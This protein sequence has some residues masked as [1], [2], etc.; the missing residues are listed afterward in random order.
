MPPLSPGNT[1]QTHKNTHQLTR[2]FKQTQPIDLQ[3][4]GLEEVILHSRPKVTAG[5]RVI[6][7]KAL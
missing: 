5:E 6:C 7:A 1:A 2:N 4:T 3:P